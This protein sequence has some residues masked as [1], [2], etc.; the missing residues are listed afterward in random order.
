MKAL[1]FIMLSSVSFGAFAQDYL[2]CS[3]KIHDNKTK[4]D[5][6]E[7]RES[8]MTLNVELSAG[9]DY[10]KDISIDRVIAYPGQSKTDKYLIR[11]FTSDTREVELG[12]KESIPMTR[13]SNTENISVR[14]YDSGMGTTA[15]F[16]TGVARYNLNLHGT[17]VSSRH[18]FYLY[19]QFSYLKDDQVETK[20]SPII[21]SCQR[22]PQKIISES[23]IKK[24]ELSSIERERQ[25][26]EQAKVN[27]Q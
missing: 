17:G 25:I 9:M 26:H 3:F 13:M 7:L 12:Q 11:L 16:S 15:H 8:E 6:K 10:K 24:G 18:H 22:L 27:Q 4:R 23:E 20:L 5:T 19:S 2:S 14:I 21:V 1:I